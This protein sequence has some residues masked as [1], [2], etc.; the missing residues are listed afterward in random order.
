MQFKKIEELDFGQYDASN[1]TNN[2]NRG[3]FNGFFVH[4]EKV[5]QIL[6]SNKY[7]ILGDKGTGKT[8]YSVYLSNNSNTDRDVSIVHMD[9]TGYTKFVEL[10]K[11]KSLILSDYLDIWTVILLMLISKFQVGRLF[12]VFMLIL[13]SSE[14]FE[15]SIII[16]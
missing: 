1:Y 12:A 13:T 7:F 11:Q 9:Q 2:L 15:K 16:I 14:S 8:A 10:K 5:D 6:E 4:D 3:L